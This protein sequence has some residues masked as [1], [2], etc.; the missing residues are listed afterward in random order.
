MSLVW[1]GF[2]YCQNCDFPL[3]ISLSSL[4]VITMGFYI[5]TKT[6][7]AH[8][9]KANRETSR[10][11]CQNASKRCNLSMFPSVPGQPYA[12]AGQNYTAGVLGFSSLWRSA[13]CTIL[14]LGASAA[15]ETGWLLIYSYTVYHSMLVWGH[16]FCF[17]D[18]STNVS[19]I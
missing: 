13:L 2:K 14:T 18:E 3:T 6:L 17:T 4:S 19:W 11:L 7:H 16:L 1:T 5:N 9:C 8:K 12:I 10:H 15:Q